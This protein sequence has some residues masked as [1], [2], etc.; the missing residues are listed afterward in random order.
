MGWPVSCVIYPPA[1]RVEQYRYIAPWIRYFS[2]HTGVQVWV[3]VA[4]VLY[5]V[6]LKVTTTLNVLFTDSAGFI[7]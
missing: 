2:L 3:V 6:G 1:L 7:W 4:C 5:I